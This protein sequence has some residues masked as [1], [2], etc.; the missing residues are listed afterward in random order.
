LPS[1]CSALPV[2]ERALS[3]KS[4]YVD[5]VINL[6]KLYQEKGEYHKA[7]ERYLSIF[8]AAK[9]RSDFLFNYGNLK[10]ELGEHENAK[11]LYEA[12]L[13]INGDYFD[14][15]FNL[16]MLCKSD[17]NITRAIILF[18]KAKRLTRN[19][20]KVDWYLS[21]CY[22]LLGQFE[23]GW[24]LY[25]SRFHEMGYGSDFPIPRWDGAR[26][27]S[28]KLFVW[29]EQGIGD[30]LMFSCLIPDLLQRAAHVNYECDARLLPLFSRTY[31]DVTFVERRAVAKHPHERYDVHCPIGDLPKIL[32][33]KGKDPKSFDVLKTSQELNSHFTFHAGTGGNTK[34]TFVGVSYKTFSVE[35][36]E[37]TPPVHFWEPI[38]ETAN[39]EF[40]DL[41]NP[42]D[43]RTS[44]LHQLRYTGRY[45]LPFN[46]DFFNDID[47]LSSL[48]WSLDLVITI[49]NYIAHL[50]G[51]L[52]KKTIIL[53]PASPNWRW[54]L[55]RSD[56]IWYP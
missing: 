29:S 46:F 45:T 49:D 2:R 18:E 9:T 34:K 52:G 3:K 51:R 36:K 33:I 50:A 37:R 26:L 23:Q 27:K 11:E 14:P 15:L 6:G 22:L 25:E 39:T 55:N 43:S 30:E 8:E 47:A 4:D 44:L 32:S 1:V 53:L 7:E 20:R 13:K 35:G 10:R 21:Q 19:S 42:P 56:T 17:G 48:L 41:Q 31:P 40:V 54:L 38:L 12:A 28:E 24:D 16:A 5:P